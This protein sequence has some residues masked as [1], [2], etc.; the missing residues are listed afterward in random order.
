LCLAI[1]GPSWMR[2][3]LLEM[4]WAAA[5]HHI[6]MAGELAALQT[7]V[8][9]VMELMLGCSPDETFQ[10]EITDELV[11]QFRKLE[12]LCSWLEWPGAKICELLLRPPPDQ[13]RVAD[14]LDEAAIRLE[15]ELIA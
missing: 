15:V 10:V 6:E 11:T 1:V 3:H 12:E 4:M 14:H 2:N 5:I 8:T 7:A 13:A 9:S